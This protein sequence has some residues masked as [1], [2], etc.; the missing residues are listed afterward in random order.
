MDFKKYKLP[1]IYK[2]NNRECYLD[3]VR[4]KLIY[5]T[6]EETVRQQVIAWLI[7]E[8]KV[9][10]NMISVEDSLSHYGL[11]S[12]DRADLIVWEQKTEEEKSPL[13]IIE[14]K[15]E[16]V[17][18]DNK[19]FKQADNYSAAL[20]TEYFMIT[21][22]LDSLYDWEPLDNDDKAK[23]NALLDQLTVEEK[24]KPDYTNLRVYKKSRDDSSDELYIMNEEGSKVL[25]VIENMY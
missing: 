3:P 18:L 10:I 6:P 4:K 16:E 1:A 23:I 7:Q 8:I 12:R 22:G 25:Y 24:D 15:A 21:N 2:R 14:C 5:V 11:S 19:V 13:L 9:P 20:G 17:P